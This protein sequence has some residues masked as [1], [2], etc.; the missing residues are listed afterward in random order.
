MITT[1]HAS[2]TQ[3]VYDGK[4]KVWEAWALSRGVDP[5]NPSIPQVCSFL[6]HQFSTQKLE[7][8]TLSGYRSMLSGALQHT[9]LN[10]A[11]DPDVAALMRHFRVVRPP[12]A[13]PFPAWDLSLVLWSLCEPPFEPMHDASKVSL[14]M[15]TWKTVFLVLL[16]SGARRGEIHAIPFKNV[17]Y[18]KEFRHVTFRPSES[19]V[20]K[21]QVSTGR[22]LP[23]F[24]IPSLRHVLEGGLDKDKNLCPCR[25]VQHYI[26]RSQSVLRQ[27]PSKQLFFVSFDSRKKGDICKNT[28]SGWVAKL[29]HFCYNQPGNKALKLTGTRAH[30]V[31]A[32]ASTL[33]SR[34]TSA[35]EDVL[36]SGNWKSHST[37]TSHYLKDI[38]DQE[39]ELFKLGPI[40]AGQKIIIP[41][42]GDN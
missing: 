9:K 15:V 8:R 42:K 3:N 41:D 29:I 34:G 36:Q 5:S 2:S 33:V 12:R 22:R 28:I 19:F 13:R 14:Q 30:E 31:R 10:I 27:D 25:A 39:G 16:A 37:F 1:P 20:A 26:Q 40:V 11:F 24:R 38:A 35:L 18:D 23:S 6:E 17:S 32:Y 21:T 4:W 7:Y